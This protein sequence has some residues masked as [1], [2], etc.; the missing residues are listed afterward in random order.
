MP[1]KGEHYWQDENGLWVENVG[2]WAKEKQKILTDYVQIASATRRKY[3][4]CAFIDVFSGPGRSKIRDSGELIDGSPV[5]AFKQG[6]RSQPFS[7]VYISDA[8]EDLLK[9]AQTRL[10][11]LAAP[12]HAVPGPASAALPKIVNGLSS[13]GLHLALLDPHNLGTLSFDLF[14]ALAKLR[15]IDVIVHVSLSDLQRNVDRYTSAA[16][17]QFDRF[18]PGWRKSIRVDQNQASLRAAILKYWTEKVVALGLPRAKH[19]ELIKG[20]GGQRLYWLMFLARH[21][22]PHS[23]WNKINSSSKQPGFDFGDGRNGA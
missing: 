11:D 13:S 2:P 10:S 12:V 8:D 5:S 7:A 23:F 21:S 1:V 18:A 16:Y 3:A 6:Q 9:S 15:K 22:L 17:E 20:S 14:E 19:C 4:H